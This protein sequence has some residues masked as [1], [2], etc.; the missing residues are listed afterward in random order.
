MP[1]ACHHSAVLFYNISVPQLNKLM[2]LT[3]RLALFDVE[4]IGLLKSKS[5]SPSINGFFCL[6][7]LQVGLSPHVQ[8]GG[9]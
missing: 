3:D 9:K 2:L 5:V 1:R 8:M 6:K 7:D 4:S